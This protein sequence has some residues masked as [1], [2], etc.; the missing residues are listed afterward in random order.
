MKKLLSITFLLTFCVAVQAQSPSIKALF[1]K[2]PTL[3]STCQQ[4][5][6]LCS[7]SDAGYSQSLLVQ[8]IFK[9]LEVMSPWTGTN[10]T[11]AV[12]PVAGFE[13]VAASANKL[14]GIMIQFNKEWD[15]K[16]NAIGLEARNEVAT[17]LGNSKPETREAAEAY[18]KKMNPIQIKVWDK[19]LPALKT[20]YSK[21]VSMASTLIGDIDK[22]ISAKSGQ[23]SSEMLTFKNDIRIR[24]VVAARTFLDK[25]SSL[26]ATLANHVLRLN[27]A[28]K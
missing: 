15:E 26:S 17:Q 28:S 25:S 13:S 11:Y 1:D 18:A 3:P 5:T 6:L 14:D 10:R 2:I 8:G 24:S 9:D 27:N 19:N 4:A 20:I 21:Y 16:V 7:A 23:E 12:K 22:V